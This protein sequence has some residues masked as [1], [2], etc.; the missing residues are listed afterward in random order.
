M[1]ISSVDWWSGRGGKL[2]DPHVDFFWGGE[3][4]GLVEWWIFFGLGSE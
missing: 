4:K 3:F 1:W 2:D